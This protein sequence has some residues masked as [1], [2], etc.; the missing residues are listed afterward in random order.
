METPGKLAGVLANDLD[1]DADYSQVRWAHRDG[2]GPEQDCR[3]AVFLERETVSWWALWL[4][5]VTASP[6][7]APPVTL[8]VIAV[9]AA[10]PTARASEL[11]DWLRS[12]LEKEGVVF[13]ATEPTPPSDAATRR[14][15]VQMTGAEWRVWRADAPD[16]IAV[17]EA[18]DYALASLETLHQAELLLGH[19]PPEPAG[20]VMVNADLAAGSELG[21][22]SADAALP[23]S[24]LDEQPKPTA[25][26]D[27][28][29]DPWSAK[30][31][32]TPAFERQWW[33]DV[34][35]GF[36]A[37][38]RFNVVAELNGS[39]FLASN[40][41]VFGTASVRHVSDFSPFDGSWTLALWDYQLDVGPML[42]VPV[43]DTFKLITG[44]K[45]GL[46]LHTYSF[47]DEDSDSRLK[48][49][50][51]LPLAFTFQHPRIRLGIRG[52]FAFST[53]TF[54][55]RVFDV[56]VWQTERLNATLVA[57]LGARLW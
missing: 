55:H 16:E 34:G 38:S 17:I 26:R 20:P 54:T 27:T 22:P 12:A 48:G 45:V 8:E 30:A 56:P 11:R 25:P 36:V 2:P 7:D 42:A 1:D 6:S 10:I 14:L 41:G 37:T 43:G 57:F 31:Y 49:V 24:G 32:T 21:A 33:A 3:C 29:G 40:W 19:A 15:V 9:S 52:E 53:A 18:G 47:T 51:T 44:V 35:V 39:V 4:A 46:G 5:N 13:A 28:F 23:R 50:A